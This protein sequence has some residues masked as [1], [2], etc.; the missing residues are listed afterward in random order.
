MYV[1]QEETMLMAIVT[2]ASFLFPIAAAGGAA[3]VYETDYE[4]TFIVTRDRSNEVTH[5]RAHVRGDR[6]RVELRSVEAGTGAEEY[7]LFALD[8][9]SAWIV[10]PAMME[11]EVVALQ[12]FVY[13]VGI[14][15]G[16]ASPVLGV[17]LD[18]V[19]V[20]G[21]EHGA[22]APIAGQA[23]QRVRTHVDYT[24]G[25]RL[26]GLALGEQRI[27]VTIDEWRGT[28]PELRANPFF[29]FL[30]T[31]ELGV[32]SADVELRRR[33]AQQRGVHG[34][35][36]PMRIE[37]AR[38]EAARGGRAARVLSS[39]VTGLRV[40]PQAPDLFVVPADYRRVGGNA[41]IIGAH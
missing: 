12:D 2:V 1:P 17:R 34:G 13:L 7:L 6:V 32:G 21:E 5:G 40:A 15:L 35:G 8:S 36:L 27:S 29:D 9:D 19:V 23:T 33:V 18:E 38:V 39:E 37:I 4:Y 3:G 24:V 26:L 10:R 41:R 22:G 11:Y 14:S 25:F 28:R 30:I 16:L 31:A 20:R